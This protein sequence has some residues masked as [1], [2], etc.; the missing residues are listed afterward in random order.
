VR[1]LHDP[2]GSGWTP[3]GVHVLQAGEYSANSALSRTHYPLQSPPFLRGAVAEPGSDAS[4]QD[5]LHRTSVEGLKDP[6]RDSEL[7]QLPEEVEALFH[8]PHQSVNVCS[9]SQ[10]L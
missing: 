1:I 4:C 5:A 2:V 3:P 8:L 9:Q 7:L 10:I 6:L